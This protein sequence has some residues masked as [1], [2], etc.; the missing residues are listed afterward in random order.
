MTRQT[1]GRSGRPSGPPCCPQ[2]PASGAHTCGSSKP[3][4]DPTRAELLHQLRALAADVPLAV[5]TLA[6][7]AVSADSAV[8]ARSALTSWTT[9]TAVFTTMTNRVTDALVKSLV[10]M[11]NTAP[12][13]RTRTSG[14]R[15]WVSTR[16]DSGVGALRCRRRGSVGSR[17]PAR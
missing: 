7:G 13:S 1:N 11:V 8:I 4:N 17:L 9:L 2:P 10:A 6:S 14:S 5:S 3:Y 12:A 16:R 15:S